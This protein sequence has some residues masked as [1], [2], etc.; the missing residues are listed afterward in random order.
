MF[1]NIVASSPLDLSKDKATGGGAQAPYNQAGFQVGM[2]TGK[3]YI[4]GGN[5]FWLA[6]VYTSMPGV[7]TH[8]THVRNLQKYH[9][10]SPCRFKRPI[11]ISV[12]DVG[13]CPL[14]HK[15]ALRTPCP[16][17]MVHAFLLAVADDILAKK[18]RQHLLQWR[19]AALN[20][21]FQFELHQKNDMFYWALN[22]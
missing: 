7:P 10:S 2:E 22:L 18:T 14:Q 3:T 20:V 4:C 6:M 1:K 5:L 11:V 13:F 21:V 9:F 15:G 19:S 17:E 8:M 12:P 16:E